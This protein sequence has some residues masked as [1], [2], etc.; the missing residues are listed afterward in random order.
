MLVQLVAFETQFGFK[1][2]LPDQ[3]LT[4][5][6]MNRALA[7]RAGPCGSR[8]HLMQNGEPDQA[9]KLFSPVSKKINWAH[10]CYKPQFTEG[11]LSVVQNCSGASVEVLGHVS[12]TADAVLMD[13]WSD[14][15]ACLVQAPV[16]P[17]RLCSLCPEGS[18]PNV[19]KPYTG[20]C[21]EFNK[22]V[23]AIGQGSCRIPQAFEH[24]R[25]H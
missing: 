7:G 18:G 24:G 8:L 2:V 25:H 13:N 10:G 16:P 6:V 14:V 12:F 22:Y 11:E 23:E 15:G 21:K 5:E 19:L 4:K 9:Q 1:R 3:R 20:K 17:F